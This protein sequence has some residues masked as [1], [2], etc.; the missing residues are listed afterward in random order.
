MTDDNEI[1]YIF[2]SKKQT[3]FIYC[4]IFL[5]SVLYCWGLIFVFSTAYVWEIFSDKIFLTFS[6]LFLLFEIIF[7][8][9]NY[10]FLNKYLYPKNKSKCIFVSITATF[11]NVILSFVFL[12]IELAILFSYF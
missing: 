9:L 7:F 5:L 12:L 1:K 11:L 6:V 3:K 10:L 4:L 2:N 8:T